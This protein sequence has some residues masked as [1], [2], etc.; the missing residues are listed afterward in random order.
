M[1]GRG[2]EGE[3]QEKGRERIREST[4]KMARERDGGTRNWDRER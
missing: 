1:E 3:E 2:K 4:R